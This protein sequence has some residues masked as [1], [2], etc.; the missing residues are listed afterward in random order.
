ME[1]NLRIRSFFIIVSLGSYFL[2]G[3]QES[4]I[5]RA[6]IIAKSMG[7]SKEE[8]K[9]ARIKGYNDDQINKA[10]GEYGENNKIEKNNKKQAVSESS[11]I[12]SSGLES[13][14]EI[15]KNE[16]KKQILKPTGIGSIS[17]GSNY[18]GYNIFKGNPEL[19]QASSVGA[20]DPNYII[21]PS[22]EII[23]M[24]WG[25][26]Q[27]RQIQTVDREGFIFLPEIGQVFVNGLTLKLLES[28]LFKVLSQSYASLKSQGISA[29]S[30]LDVTLGRLRPLRIQVLG[31]VDQPGAY[32]VN[33][34]T[35]LFS[36]LYYFKGPTNRGSLRE[37]QLI[38]TGKI[39]QSID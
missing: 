12:K 37:I 21:G 15:K 2:L 1:L 39:I 8:I 27:F 31:E 16:N 18:F 3:Q 26:T 25:E 30:F 13:P 20:I 14:S 17:S 36:A 33:P 6:K 9:E 19:F 35:T 29:T 32:T 23:I 38:R 4:E 5:K 28:K 34:S 11:L 24:L 7:L 22:D 10:L